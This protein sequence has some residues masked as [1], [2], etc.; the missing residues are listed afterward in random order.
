MDLN[1][2]RSLSHA[3][4]AAYSKRVEPVHALGFSEVQPFEG[5]RFTGYVASNETEVVL[6]FRGTA[7]RFEKS[8]LVPAT[9]QEWLT[10]LNYAQTERTGYRVHRG[11]ER[12]LDSVYDALPDVLLDHGAQ[13]K[14]LFVTG[15]SAGAALA[16][17]AARRLAEAGVPV[18]AAYVFSSPRVGDSDF[19]ESYPVPL[20]RFEYMT[21]IVPHVPFSPS[22]MSIL[23]TVIDQ[24]GPI[25]ELFFPQVYDFRDTEYIHAGV[26]FFIDWDHQLLHSVAEEELLAGGIMRLFGIDLPSFPGQPV[27]KRL[28]GVARFL[29]T[30]K[31]VLEQ[32]SNDRIQ[33]LQDHQIRSIIDFWKRI[34][35]R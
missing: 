23:D 34:T 15:H 31:R 10:N 16:T 25:I 1:V 26:Q 11:F 28:M 24:F 30:F 6:C 7:L 13:R 12:E 2:A 4:D 20:Y 27:P 35:K 29:E 22:V 5:E 9:L 8:D 3:S 14:P 18:D 32:L 17:L 33:F 19:A 21:D